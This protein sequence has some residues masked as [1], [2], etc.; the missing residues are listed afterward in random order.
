MGDERLDRLFWRGVVTCNCT[1]AAT[2]AGLLW[3][4][5][6]G[7]W[8]AIPVGFLGGAALGVGLGRRTSPTAIQRMVER[9]LT[10]K[11]S[12]PPPAVLRLGA[13][14][15]AG[16]GAFVGAVHGQLPG[17]VLGAYLGVG[18]GLSSAV[19]AW[20]IRRHVPLLVVQLLLGVAVEAVG[21]LLLGHIVRQMALDPFLMLVVAANLALIVLVR[22]IRRAVAKSGRR[23]S[24]PGQQGE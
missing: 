16:E 2:V 12:P 24:D 19:W 23:H 15:G 5:S 13:A 17:A 4:V 7:P 21:C 11:P 22:F 20:R 10:V 1:L 8:Y 18:M 9:L 6:G 14:L 3:V